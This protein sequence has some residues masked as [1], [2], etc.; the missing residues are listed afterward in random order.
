[1]EPN[2]MTDA[3]NGS[4]GSRPFLARVRELQM[5]RNFVL[6]E[7][8]QVPDGKE[9]YLL[10]GQMNDIH[11]SR[12]APLPTA[13]QWRAVEEHL[14]ALY[15]CL[16]PEQ[17][18]KY[19]LRQFPKFM[20][21]VA[22]IALAIALLAFNGAVYPEAF[23]QMWSHVVRGVL[24]PDFNARLSSIVLWDF[25][26]WN[27]A[28]G[29]LGSIAFMSVNALSIQADATFDIADA[30]FVGL[31]IM[32]GCLFGIMIALPVAYPGFADFCEKMSQVADHREA[33]QVLNGYQVSYLLLPFLVGFSTSLFM[34]IITQVIAAIQKLF[35]LNAL[36]AEQVSDR[37]GSSG[38]VRPP[39]GSNRQ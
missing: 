19:A 14:C 9:E 13:E 15:P 21:W 34:S 18:K 33:A 26:L 22:F 23:R 10:L 2:L 38:I 4:I 8:V 25:L 1:M 36:T 32:L 16:T 12:R 20:I 11:Y 37:G 5:L 31:R 28:L 24:K 39:A 30:K 17:R 7:G 3:H 29:A 35:N 27:I 6:S